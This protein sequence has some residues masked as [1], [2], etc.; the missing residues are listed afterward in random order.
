MAHSN[1]PAFN[2]ELAY[3]SRPGAADGALA[4]LP[5][6]LTDIVE[7][8]QVELDGM[9]TSKRVTL[10]FRHG[11]KRVVHFSVLRRSGKHVVQLGGGDPTQVLQLLDRCKKHFD[12]W[13]GI[14]DGDVLIYESSRK[15][16]KRPSTKG[17]AGKPLQ[18][19]CSKTLGN[20]SAK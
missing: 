6:E 3:P 11:A 18:T 4:Q 14:Q 20:N 2:A 5:S 15:K 8:D 17:P 7:F 9:P 19:S 1:K 16:S 12:N 10:W 13:F